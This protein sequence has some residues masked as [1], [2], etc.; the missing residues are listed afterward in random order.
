MSGWMKALTTS[1]GQKSCPTPGEI[2]FLCQRAGVWT[3]AHLRRAG[4]S[5]LILL[6]KQRQVFSLSPCPWRVWLLV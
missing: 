6:Y 4:D 5:H 2:L 3:Q 1:L